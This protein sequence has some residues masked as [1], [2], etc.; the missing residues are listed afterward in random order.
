MTPVLLFFTGETVPQT[1]NYKTTCVDNNTQALNQG[2]Q[3][4]PC[5]VCHNPVGWR[6]V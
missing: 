3:F 5:P 2:N 4:P 6:K 1:S